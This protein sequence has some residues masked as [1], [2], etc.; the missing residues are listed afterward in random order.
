MKIVSMVI[1]GKHILVRG[2]LKA[3]ALTAACIIIIAVSSISESVQSMAELNNNL[4]ES[5]FSTVV[6]DAG[7]GGEDGGAVSPGGIVESSLNLKVAL[8]LE[9]L[10]AFYGFE[11]VMIRREDISVH[12]P[13]AVTLRKKGVRP[14]KTG[15]YS[16]F[17]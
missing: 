7:H 4:E 3:A 12:D 10:L 8:K 16:K 15:L 17:R 14:Q 6:I 5:S 13:D 9:K 11:C 2:L 1:Q